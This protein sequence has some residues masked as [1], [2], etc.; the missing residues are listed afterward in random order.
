MI[1]NGVTSSASYPSLAQKSTCPAGLTPVSRLASFSTLP[2]KNAQAMLQALK[3]GPIA[4][5]VTVDN[6]WCASQCASVCMPVQ[7]SRPTPGS[8]PSKSLAGAVR[9]RGLRHRVAQIVH[10]KHTRWTVYS[11]SASCCRYDYTGGVFISS[12]CSGTVNHA[13]VV[14]G[15]GYDQ[16][17]DAAYWQVTSC[18]LARVLCSASGCCRLPLVP[19]VAHSHATAHPCAHHGHPPLPPC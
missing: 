8:V 16:D 4:V 10:A 1:K 3:N 13:V 9:G 11:H 19:D 6:S 12:A 14:V 7:G 5:A 17:L 2:T 15:A 18:C